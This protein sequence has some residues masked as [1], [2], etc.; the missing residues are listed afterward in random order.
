MKRIFFVAA[1]L[2][3]SC[4]LFAQEPQSAQSPVPTA[5]NQ[6]L[7]PRH[8]PAETDVVCTPYIAKKGRK[9]AQQGMAVS[10]KYLFSCE[11]GGHVNVYDF[12][13]ADGE[14]IGSFDLASSCKSNHANNAEFGVEKKKGAS[15]PLLYISI[16]KPGADIDWTCFV[17]S[18]T[19]KGDEWTSE[20]AQKIILDGKG[21]E[22]KGY[23][24]IFGAPSWLVDRER[25]ALWAF[26][27]IQRTTPKVTLSADDN[28]YVATKFRLPKLSEGEEVHLTADDIL[29]QV[30]FP[31]EVWFTQAGCI[32]DGK[33]FYGFGVGQNDP[34]RPSRIRVYDTDT[35]AIYA[36]YELQ[37]Q[38]FWEIE[39]IAIVGK[40]M[41]VGT[42]NNPKKN[43]GVDPV[44]YKVSLPSKRK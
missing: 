30:C 5:D 18:V 22:E 19:K 36:R 41:Y 20:L 40:W 24:A 29:D 7:D 1:F 17:E 9:R 3:A 14:V 42:N 25:K 38:I 26:S 23:T 2:T 21:W 35:K 32:R 37:D 8:V 4:A 27:A 13:K 6:F 44:I 39:D 31:Y 11:D 43:P 16:G 33:I 34:T 28:L 12:R 15:F 10:G